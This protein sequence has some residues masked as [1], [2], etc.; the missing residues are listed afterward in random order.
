MDRLQFLRAADRYDSGSE[1]IVIP[2]RIVARGQTLQISAILDTGSEF[3]MFDHGVADSLGIDVESGIPLRLR[4]LAGSFTAYGRE[5]TLRTYN[6]E[7]SATVYFH[8]Q[9]PRIVPNFLGRT[10][11][12][13]RIRLGLVHYDQQIYVEQYDELAN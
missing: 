3:C 11:W 6:Q 8:G 4:T 10:G 7:W 1:G 12:L 9:G 2:I 13:D 5:V